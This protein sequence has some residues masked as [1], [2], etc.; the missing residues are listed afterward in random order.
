MSP[1]GRHKDHADSGVKSG[2]Q[3]SIGCDW[4]AL[5]LVGWKFFAP[6]EIEFNIPDVGVD[7]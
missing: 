4:A 1:L 3:R 7:S 6:E 5:A 2:L